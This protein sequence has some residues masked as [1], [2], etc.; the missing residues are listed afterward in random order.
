MLN[1]FIC[2][3]SL[4][5]IRKNLDT[6]RYFWNNT[7]V[8]KVLQLF[9][10]P[11]L[12]AADVLLKEGSVQFIGDA[13]W[14]IVL[15][16]IIYILYQE[17]DQLL[18]GS[19]LKAGLPYYIFYVVIFIIQYALP[20][21]YKTHEDTIS[22][23]NTLPI[24]WLFAFG[25]SAKNQ[26]NNLRREKEQKEK[27][28]HENEALE[29][30]VRERTNEILQQKNQLEE[31]L[32]ELKQ[33]QNQLIQQEK[34]ASLG[35]LTAGI[36]H[37]IQNPLNFVNNFSE[38]STELLDELRQELSA[39]SIPENSAD[40]IEDLVQNLSKISYH[41]KRA[42]GIVKNMLEHS[43]A[44]TGERQLVDV[45]ALAEEY[46]K[47]SFHGLRAK[48]KSFNSDFKVVPDPSLPAIEAIPQDLGRVL[49]NLCNN[50]F[51]A[52]NKKAAENIPGYKPLVSITTENLPREEAVKIT[53]SDNGG[54]ISE[55]LKN[56]IFQPFFTTKPTGQGTGLGLSLS[57]DIVT[58]GHGGELMVESV[59][60]KSTVFSIILPV[61]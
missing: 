8:L 53:V 37:E 11:G 24:V 20:S 39:T 34:L 49:L 46:I 58:K 29:H 6:T 5:V 14:F 12:L 1:F 41:G 7:D 51:Y 26:I 3:F 9:V 27:V 25:L 19:L 31:T 52:V 55:E 23:I 16:Y 38:V 44:S 35:E 17:R 43:R 40:I 10:V 18:A 48:D 61:R 57:Y 47:L 22:L 45:N 36:A 4:S 60:G 13:G 30:L 42:S 2:L 54:G 15:S 56:K 21:L 28:I 59:E 32:E 50:A 33:T